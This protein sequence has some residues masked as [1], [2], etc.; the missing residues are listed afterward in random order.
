MQKT[1]EQWHTE[2]QDNLRDI[3]RKMRESDCDLPDDLGL[4][5][6]I[7]EFIDRKEHTIDITLALTE[8]KA[9]DMCGGEEE[10]GEPGRN[11]WSRCSSFAMSLD[12]SYDIEYRGH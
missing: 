7:T 8:E 10:E 6:C 5:C 3:L 1:R 11:T 4:F 2:L 12:G 9:L